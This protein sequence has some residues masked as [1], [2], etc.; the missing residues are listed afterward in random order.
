MWL[1]SPRGRYLCDWEENLLR[2][3]RI[4][5]V[6]VTATA[7]VGLAFSAQPAAAATSPSN[8]YRFGPSTSHNGCNVALLI[9]EVNGTGPAQVA[10]E[11]DSSHPGHPC[12]AW[13]ERSPATAPAKW[14]QAS[15]KVGVP[16]VAGL[17]AIANTGLV[18]DA[19]GFMAR[20]CVHAGG[21]V[22]TAKT[23]TSLV[24][25]SAGTG[26]ATSTALAASFIRREAIVVRADSAGNLLVCLGVLAS[27]TTTKRSGTTAVALLDAAGTS[28]TGFI[29]VKANSATTWTTEPSVAYKSNGPNTEVLAFT[30]HYADAP[31][32]QARLC[33]KDVTTN[34]S[35]CSKGW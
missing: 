21:T 14:A 26:T 15:G 1:I 6:V 13:V 16:S 25:L 19:P 35:N 20:A 5:I 17:E 22:A 30:A 23:C 24:K 4:G 18:G 3:K 29:Q 10:A 7:A 2:A 12:S 9:A 11:V 33:V 28:C 27:N 31:G 34:K 32:R 8:N